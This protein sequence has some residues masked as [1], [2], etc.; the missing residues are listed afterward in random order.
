V[1]GPR[2]DAIAEPEGGSVV[3]AEARAVINAVLAALRAH[4]LIEPDGL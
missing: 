1:V 3:D 2:G 4:G